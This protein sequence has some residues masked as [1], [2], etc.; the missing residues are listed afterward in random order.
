M[1]FRRDRRRHMEERASDKNAFRE[2]ALSY[3]ALGAMTGGFLGLLGIFLGWFVHELQLAGGGV[4][5]FVVRGT[6]DVSGQLAALGAIVA[7]VGGGAMLLM[8]DAR[9]G[10]W[11][12]IGAGAGAVFLLAFSAAGLFRADAALPSTGAAVAVVGVGTAFG[13]YL[14]ALGGVIATA[15]VML[16][17][18]R[19]REATDAGTWS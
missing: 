2:Q 1:L 7:F 13:A 14:S 19:D 6:Q 8:A 18:V 16:G 4:E 11:A 5:S 12:A 10:R 17:I 15:S 3:P 9:I